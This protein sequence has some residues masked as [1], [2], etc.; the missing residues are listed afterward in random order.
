MQVSRLIVFLAALS[1]LGASALGDTNGPLSLVS[2]RIAVA[3]RIVATNWVASEDGEPGFGI[4]I[5]G[6]KVKRIVKAVSAATRYRN[7][8]HPDSE[9]DWQLRFY[10]GTNLLAA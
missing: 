1:G 6:D 8:E 2:Q 10:I 3:D 5:A 9:W 7:Q 4:S